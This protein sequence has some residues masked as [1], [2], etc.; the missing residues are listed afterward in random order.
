MKLSKRFIVYLARDTLLNRDVALKL[1]KDESNI[2]RFLLENQSAGRLDHN[3]IVSCLVL[4]QIK[5]GVFKEDT[6][7][8]HGRKIACLIIYLSRVS[9]FDV[10][11]LDVFFLGK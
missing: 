3:N 8:F 2:R 7:C 9:R 4:N 6:L 1:T 11:S 5:R 10:L